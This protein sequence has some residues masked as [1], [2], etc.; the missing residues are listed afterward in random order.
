M[1][2]QELQ[3]NIEVLERNIPWA[4]DAVE[5]EKTLI[6]M[7]LN[8]DSISR[9]FCG[10]Y[11]SVFGEISN[12]STG[13]KY[14]IVSATIRLRSVDGHGEIMVDEVPYRE[15]FETLIQKDAQILAA[16][17]NSEVVDMLLKENLEMKSLLAA[18]TRWTKK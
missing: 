9:I 17:K 16:A 2:K 18:A 6:G 3:A 11:G 15:Y 1:T 8:S 14:Q 7:G 4:K 13:T 5:I 12:P 10:D